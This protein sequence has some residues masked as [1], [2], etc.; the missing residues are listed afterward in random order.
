MPMSTYKPSLHTATSDLSGVATN[1]LLMHFLV[2]KHFCLAHRNIILCKN[3]LLSVI[4]QETGG[5]LR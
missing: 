1:A 2:Y 4:I 5:P 3:T